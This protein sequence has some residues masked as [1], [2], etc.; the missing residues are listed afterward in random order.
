MPLRKHTKPPPRFTFVTPEFEGNQMRWLKTHSDATRSHAAYWSGPAKRRWQSGKESIKKEDSA[1]A[2]GTF[3]DE[4]TYPHTAQVEHRCSVAR[5]LQC[6]GSTAATDR[7]TLPQRGDYSTFRQIEPTGSRC[8]QALPP[9]LKETNSLSV[10][11]AVL[12][13]YNE[14]FM[15]RFVMVDN[16]DSTLIFTSCLLLGYAYHLALTGQ[17]TMTMLL[18]LKSQV[19]RHLTAKMNISDG[20]LSPR[21]LIA[22]LALGAPIVCLVSR[23]LPRC[24][25]IGESINMMLEEECLFS[26]ESAMFSPASLHEQVVHRSALR[27]LFLKARANFQDPESVALLQYISNYMNMCVPISF[28]EYCFCSN[29]ALRSMAIGDADCLHT[30]P[31]EIKKLFSATTPCQGCTV[32]EQWISPLTPLASQWQE[33]SSTVHN[34][35]PLM[36]LTALMQKWLA[37]FLDENDQLLPLTQELLQK[38]ADLREKIESFA[39]ATMKSNAE[40]EAMCECCRH[41]ISMLLTAEKLRIPIH[42]AAKHVESKLNLTKS[43]RQTDL[44]NLWGRHRGL[45]FWVAATCQFATASQCSP[46]LYTTLLARLVQ[47]LSMSNIYT[48]IALG[49]LK[50]LKQFEGLYCYQESQASC[51]K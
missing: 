27:R 36:L 50:R 32:P 11:L 33:D 35:S 46:L 5:T 17:G 49:S 13:F 7:K 28:Y 39:P 25:R 18:E 29:E 16:A 4:R 24:L 34:E 15:R 51:G 40:E 44:T 30:T 31:P 37:T 43:F 20:L 22:I 19:I 3:A 48:E 9:G 2:R 14:D 6:Q 23:D 45:L 12:K 42:A 38:R 41:V 47:E 8:P 21:C 10:D 26:E 1:S